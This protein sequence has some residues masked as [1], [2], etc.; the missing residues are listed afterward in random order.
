MIRILHIVDSLDMGGIQTFLLNVYKNIDC[1]NIKFDFLVFRPHK[2][3]LEEEF[4]RRGSKIYRITNWRESV[5]RNRKELK[6]FFREH[7]EYS[8]VHYHAGSINYIAPIKEAYKAKVPVRIMHSH[9]T[10]IGGNPLN[11][12]FHNFHKRSIEY[13]ATDYFACG[14][15]AAEWMF[16]GTNV[17]KKVVIIN[18]GVCTAD[19][20]YD[21]N[22]RVAKRKE[23]NVENNFVI[24]HIG[25]FSYE[26]N[27]IFLITVLEKLKK[28]DCNP[29][30]IL[31]GEGKEKEN[32]MRRAEECGVRENIKFL[33][34]R[35]DVNQLLQS[36]DI[37]LLPSFHEGFPV[38]LVEAQAAGLPCI[39]SSSISSEVAIK[40][41]V[42]RINLSDSVEKWVEEILNENER[43][44][45]NK[46]LIEA[47]FDI[48]HTAN[49]LSKFYMRENDDE[50]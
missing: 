17:E 34:I 47:G 16:G 48:E 44:I 49:E 30:L 28:T 2:Q 46:S 5:R 39:I 1:S 6:C 21:E 10:R 35:N 18:N 11:R 50:C 29:I 38:V 40:P 32:V 9:N 3:V 24:G 45:D 19:Y 20:T 43:I 23:L 27:H 15:K 25:R 22:I 7:K 8:I 41:N 26:K 33:G 31:V 4:K 37:F 12:L 14:R 13:I 36:F 42:K